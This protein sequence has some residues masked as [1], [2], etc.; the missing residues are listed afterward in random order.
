MIRAKHFFNNK[1]VCESIT[2]PY[3]I[4]YI[5]WHG[6]NFFSLQTYNNNVKI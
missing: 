5:L 6:H 2:D 3:D 4:A 1:L